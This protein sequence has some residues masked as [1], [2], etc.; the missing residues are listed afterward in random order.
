ML[1]Y[2]G[3]LRSILVLVALPWAYSAVVDLLVDLAALAGKNTHA[4]H[5]AQHHGD[6]HAQGDPQGWAY[7]VPCAMDESGFP[8]EFRPFRIRTIEFIRV[9]ASS[10]A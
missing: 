3:L 7:I 1:P 10:F 4:E 5:I 8:A 2:N 6:R 9:L